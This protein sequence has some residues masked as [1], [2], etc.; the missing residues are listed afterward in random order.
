MAD[1]ERAVS[2]EADLH[3]FYRLD[4]DR[5]V[6]T[7]TWGQPAQVA[8]WLHGA[9]TRAFPAVGGQASQTSMRMSSS[10]IPT[11]FQGAE[12]TAHTTPRCPR[13]DDQAQSGL[14]WQVSGST[15]IAAGF[16]AR[17]GP[18]QAAAASGSS[19]RSAR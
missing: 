10:C 2:L 11:I 4:L 6:R 8:D 15:I 5:Y 9:R 16:A 13:V 18:A 17:A 1:H 12:R 7:M 14:S 19:K 3:H